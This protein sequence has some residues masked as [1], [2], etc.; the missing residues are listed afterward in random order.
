M[1]TREQIGFTLRSLRKS[2]GMRQVDIAERLGITKHTI[3]KV[4]CGRWNY[5]I[6]I[7][8]A[9]ADVVGANV[10]ITFKK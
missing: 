2:K 8:L 5:G 3:S 6:E 9:Y 10:D 4:E 7:V 1:Q